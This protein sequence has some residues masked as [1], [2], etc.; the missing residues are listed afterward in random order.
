MKQSERHDEALDFIMEYRKLAGYAPSRR[1]LATALGMSLSTAQ[2]LID[3]LVE[4]KLIETT[5]GVAR[6]TIVTGSVMKHGEVAL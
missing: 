6:S 2:Q 3:D 4:Q 1:E 5:P